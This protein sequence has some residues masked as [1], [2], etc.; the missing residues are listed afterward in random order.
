MQR[1]YLDNN[2][3]T[4]LD[5][6]VLSSMLEEIEG[7]PYNSSSLHSWGRQARQLLIEA[8]D[9]IASHFSTSSF[10]VTSNQILFTSGGTE[11]LN[12]LV[13]WLTQSG[14]HI[15][16]SSI[17]HAALYEPLG[18]YAARSKGPGGESNVTFLDPSLEGRVELK[19][20]EKAIR[21]NT[22]AL[23]F[24][25]V[26]SETGVQ[27]EWETI[28]SFAEKRGLLFIVDGVALLGKEL[29]FIPKGVSAVAFSSHKLHGPKG[30]GCIV[31]SQDVLGKHPWTPLI[32]GGAQ[33]SQRRAGTE[34][35]TGII[36]FAKAVELLEKEK[37]ASWSLRIRNL[38]DQF[39]LRLQ[40]EI[41]GL[42]IN[43]SHPRVCNTSNLYFPEIDGETLLL[44]LDQAG[45]AAS[46]GSAC[47]SGARQ[48]SRV[49]L[50]MG[51]SWKEAR[52]CLRFSLA[53]TTTEAEME[54]AVAIICRTVHQLAL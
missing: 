11:S 48:P 52:S 8:K 14:G 2:A 10:P 15:I 51:L 41:P 7:G 29:F 26:N 33:E 35:L 36:G 50:K 24:S 17:E 46:L 54:R 6:A 27:L 43:G 3:T 28:A 20:I 12:A 42:K 32:Q 19:Q 53:R 21:P 45:I 49:L 31:F 23:F 40:R 1:I 4:A 44:A 5:P 16:S 9:R 13:Y 30:V 47:S 37:L 38:R 39:E 34:N 25:V 18:L 22:K